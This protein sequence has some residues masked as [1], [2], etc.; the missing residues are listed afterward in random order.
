MVNFFRILDS[1]RH[2]LFCPMNFVADTYMGCPHACWYCYAPSF[3]VRF[4]KHADSF[5][6]F[7]NFKRRF[8][9]DRDLEKIEAAIERGEVKGTYNKKQAS[10][11]KEA[12]KHRHPLRIGSVSEPFGLPLENQYENTPK[13][14]GIHIDMTQAVLEK[15]RVDEPKYPVDKPHRW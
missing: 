3:V 12:I 6:G 7:R 1:D 4:K 9:S 14:I 2:V 8:K 5:Q 10:F 13:D 11:I 15:L